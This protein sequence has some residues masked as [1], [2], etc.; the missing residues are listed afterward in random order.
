MIL[1]LALMVIVV[2]NRLR[3]LPI[4]RAW[5][6]LREDEIACRSLGINIPT[7]KLTAFATGAMF[8]G[9]LY[10]DSLSEPDGP[11]PTYLDLLAVTS[12]TIA[13]GLGGGMN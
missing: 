11:V 1:L 7:S 2:T 8:G 10:V 6:A 4:G 13:D 9:V 5:E 3:R 12:R